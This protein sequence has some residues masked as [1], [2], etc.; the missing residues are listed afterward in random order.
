MNPYNGYT[1]A[2]RAA[3]LRAWHV[4]RQQ[5]LAPVWRAPCSICADPSAPVERHAED[6]SLPFS[7][8]PPAEYGLCR[9]C[10]RNHLHKRFLNPHGWQ[11]YLAHVRRGGYST[12]LHEPEIR[13]QLRAMKFALAN[14]KRLT[15]PRLRVRRLTGNEWWERLSLDPKSLTASWA[16]PRP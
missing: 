9:S 10:H 4:L 7:W 8:Q 16:R 14:S 13:G 2:E 1:G 3:K 12:D 15:L 11:A 6:Y 5:G